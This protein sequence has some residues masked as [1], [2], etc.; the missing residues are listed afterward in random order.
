MSKRYTSES[1]VGYTEIDREEP[2]VFTG[3]KY[4]P[5]DQLEEGTMEALRTQ[6]VES[7]TFADLV[8]KAEP[9]DF[10]QITTPEQGVFS[11]A[12]DIAKSAGKIGMQKIVDM[13][14]RGDR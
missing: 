7:T 11:Q 12:I 13:A 5:V 10:S 2:V 3:R 14:S 8:E 9:V 1:G 6:G 4:E